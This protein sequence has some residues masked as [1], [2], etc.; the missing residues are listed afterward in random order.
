MP[1]KSEKADKGE[2]SNAAEVSER[3]GPLTAALV[4]EYADREPQEVERQLRAAYNR[5]AEVLVRRVQGGKVTLAELC[6]VV[7]ALRSVKGV[8]DTRGDGRGGK[9]GGD[10][11]QSEGELLR[12]L[13]KKLREASSE[14][15][16]EAEEGETGAPG[17]VGEP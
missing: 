3:S 1:R 6:S 17:L 13:G 9:K 10:P 7:R 2:A 8:K 14:G 5:A 15:A 11:K 12:R 4:K 16:M